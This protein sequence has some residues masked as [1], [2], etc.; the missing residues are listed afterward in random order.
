[1]LPDHVLDEIATRFALGRRLSFD[2]HPQQ[3]ELGRVW[4]LTS[5]E[6]SWAVKELLQPL[7]EAEVLPGARLQEAAVSAGLPAPAVVRTT[8]GSVLAEVEGRQ[9]RVL[10]WVDVRPADITLDAARVGRLVAALH[11]LSTPSEGEADPWYTQPV[12]QD[13]WDDL[14]VRL[15]AAWSPLAAV[16]AGL[17][18][19]LCR[20]EELLEPPE[21]LR[22]LH[23][24]LWADNVRVTPA[25]EL[26]VLDWDNSGLGDPRQELAVVLFEFTSW[27][28][29]RTRGLYSAYVDAGGPA[30]ISRA[31][32]FSMA[33]AQL[34][35][36]LQWQCQNWLS[37]GTLAG[38]QHAE[39][40]VRE[41]VARPLTR[42]VVDR[43]VDA[44]T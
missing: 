24:D 7:S 31:A 3:G 23:L 34:G 44:L 9:F 25:G 14:V 32:D 10:S 37:V 21:T 2:P 6:G 11:Q 33:V 38:Q 41:F 19:E 42:T 18:H 4:R 16:V 27:S 12:G 8:D 39:A 40:A 43:M 13:G 28:P 15:T 17:R 30:R 5:T 36:I 29:E 35:H 26:C 1:M 22:P 20:N